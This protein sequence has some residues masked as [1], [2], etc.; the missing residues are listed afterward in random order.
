MTVPVVRVFAIRT[1][2]DRAGP[3]FAAIEESLPERVSDV[4]VI[5]PTVMNGALLVTVHAH[6]GPPSSVTART[7]VASPNPTV[8]VVGVTWNRHPEAGGA[9]NASCVTVTDCP[10]IVSVAERAGPVFAS[11]AYVT[12]PVPVPDVAEVSRTNDALLA[13]VHAQ[14]APCAAVMVM[15]PDPP[16]WLNVRLISPLR[17]MRH[18]A[19]SWVIVKVTPATTT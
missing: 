14:L 7:T 10:A 1:L 15:E 2:P 3:V 16:S 4:W 8:T 13:A 6:V 5:V 19:V 18:G 12:E 9:T 17:T 11:T